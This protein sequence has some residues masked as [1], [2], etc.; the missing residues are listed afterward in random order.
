MVT[1]LLSR[2]SCPDIGKEGGH[3]PIN[4]VVGTPTIVGP[5]F[6]ESIRTDDDKRMTVLTCPHHAI[7]IR[8]VGLRD[9]EV[10]IRKDG[11]GDAFIGHLLF[12]CAHRI[13]GNTHDGINLEGLKSTSLRLHVFEL[14][15]AGFAANPFLKVQQDGFATQ[16]SKIKGAS[17]GRR[18]R[19]S[20]C[21][22]TWTWISYL[23]RV[24]TR[25]TTTIG[26]VIEEKDH[27]QYDNRPRHDHGCDQTSTQTVSLP[28]HSFARWWGPPG[29]PVVLLPSLGA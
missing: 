25:L 21:L 16:R 14:V 8:R 10:W 18:K 22:C 11:K 15:P 19:D 24:L 23:K 4:R 20:G 9:S 13:R 5:P 27:S 3:G 28:H 29:R 12:Q 2:Q 7:A 17:V 1:F 6:D 26:G